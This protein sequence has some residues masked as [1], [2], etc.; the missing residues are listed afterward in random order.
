MKPT[1]PEADLAEPNADENFV[2]RWSR[3]KSVPPEES[4]VEMLPAKQKEQ[5]EPAPTDADMPPID[6][7]T[8]D[9]DYSCFMSPAVSEPLR[10]LALRRLFHGM[11]FNQRDGLDDYD[12]DFTDFTKLADILT[13]DMR[14]RIEQESKQIKPDG[15][16][17]PELQD[18]HPAVDASDP[19]QKT[20]HSDEAMPEPIEQPVP[21]R[22][23]EED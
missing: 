17:D 14:H 6:T 5:I 9:S 16:K 7:L 11:E 23:E 19:E 13:S 22:A 8:A 15:R 1:G 10:R 3:L 12:D 4:A 20:Q 2:D 18:T 21:E